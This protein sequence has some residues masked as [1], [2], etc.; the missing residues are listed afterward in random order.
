MIVTNPVARTLHALYGTNIL[1]SFQKIQT[2][3]LPVFCCKE[4][5]LKY[6]HALHLLVKTFFSEN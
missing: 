1:H 3:G 4:S 2:V 5:C 6:N